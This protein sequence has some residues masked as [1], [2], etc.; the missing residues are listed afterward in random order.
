MVIMGYD[1]WNEEGSSEEHKDKLFMRGLHCKSQIFRGIS[2]HFSLLDGWSAL[3][4][5]V[6]LELLAPF[7]CRIFH[8]I[9]TYAWRLEYIYFYLCKLPSFTHSGFQRVEKN[10]I[11]LLLFLVNWTHFSLVTLNQIKCS[12]LTTTHTVLFW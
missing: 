2:P 9:P 7:S 8:K 4:K 10:W 11:V 6:R 3:C 1:A 5:N 12:G